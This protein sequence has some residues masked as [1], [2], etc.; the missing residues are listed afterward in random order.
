MK[1]NVLLGI[2]PLFLLIH[3]P[4]VMASNAESNAADEVCMDCFTAPLLFCPSTYFGCPGDNI[5]PL[6]TGQP[7]ALPGDLN[8]PMPEVS[9]T[10]TLVTD[11]PC[12]KK[13]HRIWKAQYPAGEADPKLFSQCI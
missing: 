3:G 12:F 10:D 11:T 13:Y 9:Y 7:I 1:R 5:D 8:C 4:F 6:L 2:L